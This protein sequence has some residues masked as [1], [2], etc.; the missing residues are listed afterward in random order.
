VKIVNV[1]EAKTH[2]SSLIARVERRG[3]SVVICRNGEPVANLVPHRRASR[4]V[5]HPALS[6]I[7]IKYNPTAPLDDDEWPEAAR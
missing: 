6:R 5:A 4:I 2:F 7:Q 1:H 3:E